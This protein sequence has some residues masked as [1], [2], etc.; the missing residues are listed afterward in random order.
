MNT[1]VLLRNLLDSLLLLS[2]GICLAYWVRMRRSERIDRHGVDGSRNVAGKG[3]A[4]T[5]EKVLWWVALFCIT[6]GACYFLSCLWKMEGDFPDL[7]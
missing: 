1:S 5:V 3:S 4:V 6:V 2:S 7:G